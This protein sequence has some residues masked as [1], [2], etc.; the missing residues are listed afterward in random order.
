[1]K[2][3]NFAVIGIRSYKKKKRMNI[4]LKGKIVEK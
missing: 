1:M 2:Y 4:L 3:I